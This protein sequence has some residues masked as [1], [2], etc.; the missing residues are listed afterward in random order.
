MI[1]QEVGTECVL[2]GRGSAIVFV[3]RP[4]WMVLPTALKAAG[5]EGFCEGFQPSG[6]EGT[7]TRSRLSDDPLKMKRKNRSKETIIYIL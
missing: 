4:S 1:S 5:N 6:L 2:V 3:T 7:K